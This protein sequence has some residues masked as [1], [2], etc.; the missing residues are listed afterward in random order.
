[1]S[2]LAKRI[3]GVDYAPSMIALAR[4][5]QESAAILNADFSVASTSEAPLHF[6]DDEFDLVYSRRGPSSHL[7]DARR[8]LRKG[9]LVAGLHTGDRERLLG[10]VDEAG[11]RLLENKEFKAVEVLPTLDDFALY[12]QNPRISELHDPR[13]SH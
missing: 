7:Q 6:K 8:V 13:A 5:Y 1:M 2:A 3:V 4:G 12:L 11:F 10:R 9:G